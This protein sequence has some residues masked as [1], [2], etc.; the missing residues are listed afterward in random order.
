MLR[1][2]EI[3]TKMAEGVFAA[4]DKGAD[5]LVGGGD[6]N[7]NALDKFFADGSMDILPIFDFVSI[8][9]QG[10]EA[11]VLYRSGT[12]AKIIKAASRYGIQRVG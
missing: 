1:Y 10:L 9:Y 11:P 3:Y 6:S 4:R 8:H 5:V 2:R 7:S 12:S